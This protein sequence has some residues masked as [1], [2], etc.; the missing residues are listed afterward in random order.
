MKRREKRKSDITSKL[1]YGEYL[2]EHVRAL[3]EE[4]AE[5]GYGDD[6]EKLLEKTEEI[7]LCQKK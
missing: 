3:M 2:I 1:N 6:V 7:L 4:A 5:N